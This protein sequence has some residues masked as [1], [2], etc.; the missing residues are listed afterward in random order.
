MSGFGFVK[1]FG[2]WSGKNV[3]FVDYG[4][5]FQQSRV[6]KNIQYCRI[7]LDFSENFLKIQGDFIYSPTLNLKIFSNFCEHTWDLDRIS[8]NYMASHIDTRNP[9]ASKGLS[10]ER[11]VQLLE[12]CF[13]TIFLQKFNKNLFITFHKS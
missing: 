3:G 6:S 8:R 10:A 4:F 5:G 7:F 1:I 11:V 12:A 13:S 9:H 2:L